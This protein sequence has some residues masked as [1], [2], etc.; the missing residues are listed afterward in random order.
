[1]KR[2]PLYHWKKERYVIGVLV[3]RGVWVG[4]GPGSWSFFKK[5]K[6]IGPDPVPSLNFIRL[7]RV[8]ITPSVVE[9]RKRLE[10]I[11]WISGYPVPGLICKLR[12]HIK[13]NNSPH[14][15][16]HRLS[17]PFSSEFPDL[18]FAPAYVHSI[19]NTHVTWNPYA[20]QTVSLGHLWSHHKNWSTHFKVSI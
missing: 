17:F 20:T 8:V 14:G 16:F 19:Y 9:R 2:L 15:K 13:D 12:V 18:N 4:A 6:K 10:A 7:L 5:K 11:G 3:K 1:M